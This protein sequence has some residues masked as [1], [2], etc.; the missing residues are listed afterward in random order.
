MIRNFLVTLKLFPNTNSIEH[1]DFYYSDSVNTF[2]TLHAKNLICDKYQWLI[3]FSIFY[4]CRADIITL[5]EVESDQFYNFFLFELA[6]CGY[7][8]VFSP[9]S[10][11]KTMNE[12]ERKRVDGCAIFFKWVQLYRYQNKM[13]PFISHAL[14]Y[15][16]TTCGQIHFRGWFVNRIY[17]RLFF[18][19]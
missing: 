12:N 6:Q 5:Q 13:F 1:F 3:L 9:K 17:G 15:I 16:G 4:P 14:N 2:W 19:Y 10:R 11:A 8:G 18:F 7:E